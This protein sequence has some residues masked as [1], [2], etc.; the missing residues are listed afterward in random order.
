MR[1][2]RGGLVALQ[3]SPA[4]AAAVQAQLRGA[5]RDHGI[6]A[7]AVTQH[8]AAGGGGGGG[9]GRRVLANCPQCGDAVLEDPHNQMDAE[10][11]LAFHQATA[12]VMRE[13]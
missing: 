10:N 8:A 1:V 4:L 5:L 11:A 2:V 9:G 7:A 3:G 13:A 12:C 6:E